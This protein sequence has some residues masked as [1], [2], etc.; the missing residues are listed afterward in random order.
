[1]EYFGP[2]QRNS[3]GSAM[4]APSESYS[5]AREAAYKRKL[6]LQLVKPRLRFTGYTC[7][8]NL[9]VAERG[10]GRCEWKGSRV[11]DVSTDEQV[12]R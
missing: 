10:R 5:I 3:D 11:M 7:E 12:D 1:M 8:G 6:V 2:T 9:G 4:T